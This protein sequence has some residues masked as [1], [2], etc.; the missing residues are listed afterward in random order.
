MNYQYD[1]NKKLIWYSNTSTKALYFEDTS[2]IVRDNNGIIKQIIY[3][4]D[5]SSKYN[6]PS[7]DSIVFNVVY[8]GIQNIPIKYRSTNVE[9]QF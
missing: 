3:R 6:D 9:D 5:T 2:K 1:A 4:S 8:D 7:L